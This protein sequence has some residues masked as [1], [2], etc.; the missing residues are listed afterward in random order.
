MCFAS[1]QTL[2]MLN[3]LLYH[4]LPKMPIDIILALCKFCPNLIS[5][6]RVELREAEENL[7]LPAVIQI[8][9]K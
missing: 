4:R 2:H 7:V 3:F 5:E 9:M 6:L 1:V 8:I